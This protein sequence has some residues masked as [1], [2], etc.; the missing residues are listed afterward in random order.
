MIKINF[1]IFSY[2]PNCQYCIALSAV[3]AELSVARLNK[4]HVGV[5]SC[6]TDD[7]LCIVWDVNTVPAM[8]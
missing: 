4:T 1:L 7:P 5:I 3:W 8:I 2:L 6:E